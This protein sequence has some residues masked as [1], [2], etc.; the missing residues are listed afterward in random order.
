MGKPYPRLPSPNGCIR[1]WAGVFF[2]LVD[3]DD[4]VFLLM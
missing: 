3:N 1:D 2:C 4:D